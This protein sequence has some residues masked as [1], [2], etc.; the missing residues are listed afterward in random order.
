MVFIHKHLNILAAVNTKDPEGYIKETNFYTIYKSLW[1]EGNVEIVN[2]KTGAEIIKD[3][4][5]D[6]NIT[7]KEGAKKNEPV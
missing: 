1:D 6:F 4:L 3:T 5:K 7:I 2:E